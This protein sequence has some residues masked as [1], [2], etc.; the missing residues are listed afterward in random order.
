MTP[1]SLPPTFL[2]DLR[3]LEAAY[4]RHSDPICQSGF[5]GGSKRLR[6][7]REPIVDAVYVGNHLV[8][9]LG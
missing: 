2:D 5:G 9:F 7:E 8:Y 4:C 3:A 6:E 1:E